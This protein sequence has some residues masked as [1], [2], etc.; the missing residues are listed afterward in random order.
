[1]RERLAKVEEWK[2]RKQEIE[3]EL[4]KVW[5]ND[6]EELA[7]PAYV[8]HGEGPSMGE[9]GT[10]TEIHDAVGERGS[11]DEVVSA[12]KQEEAEQVEQLEK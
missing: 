7:P 12:G 11:N 8:E 10:N 9:E 6:G 4:N 3:D 2:R 1:M 5:V